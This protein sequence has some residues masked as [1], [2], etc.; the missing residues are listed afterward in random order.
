M[1]LKG[2]TYVIINAS[3]LTRQRQQLSGVYV[4][5]QNET[6]QHMCYDVMIRTYI[7]NVI[8]STCKSN[9]QPRKPYANHMVGNT[10]KVSFYTIAYAK[11]EQVT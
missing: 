11:Q 3:A 6:K 9:L 2:Q 8:T 5:K 7:V 4:T 1:L 10:E